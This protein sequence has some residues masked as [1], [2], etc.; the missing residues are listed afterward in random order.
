MDV[1]LLT[2][3]PTFPGCV[4][5]AEAIGYLEMEDEGGIDHKVIA[6]PIEKIDPRWKEVRDIKDFAFPLR[7][8]IKDVS[9][10]FWKW[11]LI[12][13]SE[14]EP[15]IKDLLGMKEKQKD[16]KKHLSQIDKDLKKLEKNLAV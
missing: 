2:T 6:V 8:N 1:V 14:A 13:D 15:I 5:Q 11:Y 16:V 9:D 7:V 12:Q 4:V 10:I 3:H